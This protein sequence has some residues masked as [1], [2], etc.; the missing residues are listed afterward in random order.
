M[1][2]RLVA[3]P[4]PHQNLSRYGIAIL[5]IGGR[6]IFPFIQGYIIYG[7]GEGS[8]M[9]TPSVAV[10]ENTSVKVVPPSLV[11]LTLAVSKGG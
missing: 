11:T 6:I 3:L 10:F 4:K 2:P 1:S 5:D 8:A 7:E 9:I